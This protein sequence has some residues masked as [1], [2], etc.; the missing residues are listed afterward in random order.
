MALLLL[1]PFLLA[2]G[3]GEE[4][5]GDG[6]LFIDGPDRSAAASLFLSGLAHDLADDLG[7]GR[8]T[9]RLG[10]MAESPGRARLLRR[11]DRLYRNVSSLRLEASDIESGF[12]GARHTLRFVFRESGTLAGSMLDHEA[13]YPVVWRFT[14]AG[15]Q[16]T[17]VEDGIA[18]LTGVEGTVVAPGGA[19]LPGVRIIHGDRVVDTTDDDG[20]YAALL[21]EGARGELAF[22]REGFRAAS[23]RLPRTTAETLLPPVELAPLD[24]FFL[25]PVAELRAEAGDAAITLRFRLER[26]AERLV[27]LRRSSGPFEP[28]AELPP[29]AEEY[30][31]RDGLVNGRRYLYRVIPFIG[32]AR[33]FADPTVSATPSAEILRIEGESLLEESMR[34]RVKGERPWVVRRVGRFED[35]FLAFRPAR[36]ESLSCVPDA[37]L[38]PGRYALVAHV[39]RDERGGRFRLEISQHGDPDPEKAAVFEVD[40]RARAAH[41]ASLDLGTLHVRPLDWQAEPLP[42]ARYGLTLRSVPLSAEPDR[43]ILLDALEF[44]KVRE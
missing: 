42:R 2:A 37:E 23:L 22:S 35:L 38:T 26:P 1:L 19:P 9:R 17:L 12:D 3:C 43:A 31:D 41:R 32:A 28:I 11:M 7:E 25:P 5:T 20:R 4:G 16:L 8:N 39:L 40:T 30:V 34:L 15:D 29:L 44:V 6:R 14:I 36:T 27:V 21:P 24:G 18:R 33:S 10:F 13:G